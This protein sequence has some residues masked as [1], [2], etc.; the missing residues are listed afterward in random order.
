MYLLAQDGTR[1]QKGPNPAYFDTGSTLA[2]SWDVAA[3]S[4]LS[5]SRVQLAWSRRRWT[6]KDRFLKCDIFSLLT[7]AHIALIALI[8]DLGIRTDHAEPKTAV[9]GRSD[10]QGDGKVAQRAMR[11]K[12]AAVRGRQNRPHT[13]PPSR[14]RWDARH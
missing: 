4:S 2:L 1:S 9:S 14:F 12:A 11:R 3:D 5:C 6:G 13:R 10:D 7:N 8:S